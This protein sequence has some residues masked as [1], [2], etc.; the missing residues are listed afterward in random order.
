V[1]G[2]WH[3]SSLAR[4]GPAG[5]PFELNFTPKAYP[6]RL[7]PTKLNVAL[8]LEPRVVIA[9]IQTTIINDSITAY[10]TAVGPSSFFRNENILF[11][12]LRMG[13]SKVMNL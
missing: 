3:Q 6:L 2:D 8:A 4:I 13:L 10:S 12:R 9:A 7:D 1:G 5:Q 11:V